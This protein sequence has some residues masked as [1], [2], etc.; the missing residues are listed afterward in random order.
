MKMI[1]TRSRLSAELMEAYLDARRHKLKK[2]YTLD[3]ERDLQ[4]NLFR[5]CDELLSRVYE[6][7]PSSCF[8]IRDPKLREIF[9]ADFR[10]RIVH[11]LYYN[12][13]HRLFERT[14]IADSYSCI[15]GRGTHYGIRRLEHHIRQESQNYQEACYVLKMD[16]R[17]YF[18]HISRERL[19]EEVTATLR[20]MAHHEA[21][22]M[23]QLNTDGYR[24]KWEEVIDLDFVAYLSRLFILQ[25][26]VLGCKRI[27]DKADWAALP[28]TKSLFCSPPGCGLPIGNLTSQLFSNVYLNRLD[29]YAKRTLRCRHYGRYVD[30]FYVVSADRE[31]LRGLIPQFRQFLGRELGLSLSEEKT[32]VCDVHRGV[33]YLG[34]WLLPGRIYLRSSTVNRARRHLRQLWE[35]ASA[36]DDGSECRHHEVSRRLQ[37]VLSSY[38]GLMVHWRSYRLRQ[39]LLTIENDFSR[40]GRFDENL[41]R[42][43][44]RHTGQYIP[45]QHEA[46]QGRAVDRPS[47]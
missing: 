4:G 2:P 45:C 33:E 29:Q 38:C 47:D 36:R 5:L 30:D 7:R 9:A 23:H 43:V 3:F 10:D 20:R 34:A 32:I 19:F 8:L 15:E 26:P 25:D 46:R 14:F 44:P 21:D 12:C 27:G 37:D 17:G 16:I 42:F 31:W 40:W 35:W 13:T 41:G 18:M 22:E 6:P 28:P 24:R 39:R 11:H 1:L